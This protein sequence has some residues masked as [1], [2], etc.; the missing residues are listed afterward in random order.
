MKKHKR[1]ADATAARAPMVVRDD[2]VAS[3]ALGRRRP[4]LARH[5][6]DPSRTFRPARPVPGT[7]PAGIAMDDAPAWTVNYAGCEGMGEGLGFLG[8]QYLAELAQR[9]EYR[10]PSEMIAKHMTR[11]WIKL[12][13][14]GEEDKSDKVKA[15]YA[16]LMRLGARDKFCQAAEYDGLFGRSHI[17]LDMGDDTRSDELKTPLS[18][19]PAK[20]NKNRPLK[21]ISIVEAMWLTPFNYNSSDPLSDDF[22]KPQAWLVNGQEVHSSRFLTFVSR[23]MP[24]MLKPAYSF[25]GLSLS[26][27]AKPYVD[28]WL[29]TRQSVSDLIHSFT[30]FVMSLDL[31]SV[32]TGGS[33]SDALRRLEL[34]NLARDNL[35]LFA[36]NKETEAFDNISAPITGLDKLQAQAQEQMAACT[37]LPLVILLGITPSGLNASSEGELRT[38]FDWISALQEFLFRPLLE[39]LIKIIQLSLFGEIDPEITFGFEPLWT[40]DAD[41]VAA[42][43]KVEA[44]TAVELINASV[45]DNHEFRTVL[46]AQE[47]SPYAALDLSITPEPT[48][49]PELEGLMDRQGEGAP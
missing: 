24:D 45:I 48:P 4:E 42:M 41:K 6:T 5:S 32:V 40:M 15:I 27:M 21:K 3:A 18:I 49:S 10:R 25:G 36:I 47:D 13:A 33:S 26:Q 38:F 17:F 11:K 43:R 35:G 37:G 7:Q 14:T 30:V 46:A 29:R 12:R 2:A 22:Y 9:P 8:S 39:Q 31:Q 34:F 23:P 1:K 19:D 44:D 28:N 16:E 20:I